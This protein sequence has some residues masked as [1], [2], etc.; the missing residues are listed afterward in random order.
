MN[1]KKSSTWGVAVLVAGVLALSFLGAVPTS[2]AAPAQERTATVAPRGSAAVWTPYTGI[3]FNQP[4]GTSEQRTRIV[5]RIHEAI[6]HTPPG[7]TIRIAT[8]NLGLKASADKLIAAKKRGVRVQVIVN[9]N[10]IGPLEARVQRAIG[11]NPSQSSFL[12]FCKDAC[13]NPSVH[14]NMHLKVYSFTRI[15]VTRKLLISSSS[16]LGGPAMHGQWNDSIAIAGEDQ[17]FATWWALFDQLRKDRTATPR[18]VTYTS[19]RITAYFQRPFAGDAGRVSSSATVNDAPYVRLSK[20]SC[21]APTGFGNSLGKTVITV[22]MRAWYG[23]R[24]ARLARLLALRKKYG[25]S[26]KVIGSLMSKEVVRIL[27]GARIPVKAADWDW[28]PRPSTSD[29]EKTVYGPS[30]Y[31]HLKYVTVNGAYKSRGDRLVWAG[32]E[33]WSPPGLSSDEVTFEIHDAKV[34]KAYNDQFKRMWD[35]TRA[36]HRVGIEPRTRPCAGS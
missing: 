15:G 30:C 23:E 20:V 22:N 18:R 35:S 10:L 33:N 31:A 12:I 36:T 26:V 8:Y 11:R 25:C 1:A 19:D 28:G 16:N 24:G 2:S 7:E 9:A 32:S 6:D 27:V 14:G 17:L 3:T 34:V 5:R 13:R 21:N 4:T 29:A